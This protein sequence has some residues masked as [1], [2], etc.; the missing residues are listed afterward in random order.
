MCIIYLSCENHS[1]ILKDYLDQLALRVNV[2]PEEN[3]VSQAQLETKDNKEIL[4]KPDL[5]ETLEPQ[6]LP[7]H[8]G[9]LVRLEIP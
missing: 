4:E 1:F 2:A 9:Q 8:L 6:D 7:D 3:R 5:T